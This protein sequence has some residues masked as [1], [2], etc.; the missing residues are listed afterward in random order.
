M[1]EK[2]TKDIKKKNLILRRTLFIVFLIAIF[3]ILLYSSFSDYNM[4]HIF[5]EMLCLILGICIFIISVN[6]FDIEN[7]RYFYYLGISFVL[8]DAYK[9]LHLFTYG[10]TRLLNSRNPYVFSLKCGTAA[11][12]TE[13]FTYSILSLLFYRKD[14]QKYIIGIDA[15]SCIIICIL[16]FGFNIIEFPEVFWIICIIIFGVT[17]VTFIQLKNKLSLYVFLMI[18][19]ANILLLVSLIF[20]LVS[21]NIWNIFKICGHILNVFSIY[22]IFEAISENNLKIPYNS[23]SQKFSKTN[24][25]LKQKTAELED[26]NK[27]LQK[28]VCK[29]KEIEKSLRESEAKYRKVVELSPDAI[30]LHENN[31]IM[32]ANSSA[33]NFLN[34]K[35][36]RNII[37]KDIFDY[38]SGE[39]HEMAKK[40]IQQ[41]N[42]LNKT[43]AFIEEVLITED[44]KRNYV[45]IATTPF[46]SDGKVIMTLIRDINELKKAEQ[47][48]KLLDEAIEYDKLRTEFFANISHELRTPLN[49][50]YGAVQ[51]IE[52][53][54]KNQMITEK[55]DVLTK[56]IKMMRQN[57][58][59]LLRLVNNLIDITRIDSGFYKINLKNM[60]IVSVVE[61]ITMS[62]V[63][64]AANKSI[65]LLFD[66]EIEEKIM[67]IDPDK[68]ERIMLNLLSNSVKF[69]EPGGSI[70]VNI[71]DKKD[72]IVI[73]VKDNGVGIPEEKLNMI[74]ERFVQVDKSLNRSH[75]GSG[76]GLSLVKSLVEMHKGKITVESELGK[77]SM[78][79]IELPVRILNIKYNIGEDITESK[80][81][82]ADI[83]FSDIYSQ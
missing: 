69:T 40:R 26:I 16:I 18:E 41:V 22:F 28:D 13:V 24:L 19:G 4:F 9:I 38:I 64:Y 34:V 6:T 33:I 53:Y 1:S 61:D 81:E 17:C 60:N 50:I 82:V 65:N 14:K 10:S 63:Q 83:E 73:C 54:Y 7:N 80:T 39:Y 30:I 43:C 29:R 58:L 70:W 2:Y 78:F 77:G 62:I 57:S 27:K 12:I 8:I 37:G 72:K 15:A 20:M 55:E 25:Q 68:I 75:E 47:N 31:K 35:C 74:F 71:Y 76:I 3:V 51:L 36:A 5:S 49:V 21:R 67:S 45:E 52:L 42:E 32:Y 79:T 59:R 66:T 23:I 48:K 44:G 56:N 46:S 11:L